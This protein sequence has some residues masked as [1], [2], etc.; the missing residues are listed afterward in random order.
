MPLHHRIEVDPG[1]YV[2]IEDQNG[3][4]DTPRRKLNCTSGSKGVGFNYVTNRQFRFL[5]VAHASF[6]PV[7]TVVQAE[8]DLV[9]FRDLPYQIQLV[10]KKRSVEDRNDGFRGFQGHGA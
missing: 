8:N 1:E 2:T 4:V 6:D 5:A 10:K 3:V 9:D 7:G